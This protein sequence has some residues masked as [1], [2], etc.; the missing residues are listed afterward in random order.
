MSTFQQAPLEAQKPANVTF[1]P[2]PLDSRIKGIEIEVGRP[3][4]TRL[5]IHPGGFVM[6]L[7]DKENRSERGFTLTVNVESSI[8]WIEEIGDEFKEQKILGYS[9]FQIADSAIEGV[10]EKRDLCKI[11][12]N[13]VNGVFRFRVNASVQ[14]GGQKFYTRSQENYIMVAFVTEDGVVH[15][16]EMALPIQDNKLWL[17]KQNVRNH[18]AF[19]DGNVAVYPDC[20]RGSRTLWPQLSKWA[21]SLVPMEVAEDLPDQSNW[22][23]SAIDFKEIGEKQLLVLWSSIRRQ[24]AGGILNDGVEITVSYHNVTDFPAGKGFNF[25]AQ[26][27][28]VNYRELRRPQ[29]RSAYAYEAIGVSHF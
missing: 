1:I 28:I 4:G 9:V 3:N 5:Q 19:R 6:D 24:Q 16:Y 25:I 15:V 21:S 27:E 13:V 2:Q 14:G 26:D 20:V 11:Q 12:T 18:K 22:K 8:K 7:A 29:V 17:Y 23:E 10:C